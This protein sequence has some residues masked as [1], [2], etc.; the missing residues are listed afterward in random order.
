MR[1]KI[2]IKWLIISKIFK[3]IFNH[4]KNYIEWDFR[5]WFQSKCRDCQDWITFKDLNNIECKRMAKRHYAMSN[6]K[7]AAGVINRQIDFK[8]NSGTKNS[9]KDIL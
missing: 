2:N 5:E 7:H 3:K 1:Q 4:I 6:H 9:K 8:T